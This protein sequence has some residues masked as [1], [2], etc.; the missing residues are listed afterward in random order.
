MF[1]T[2]C[3]QKIGED[4]IF[5]SICGKKIDFK[6][7]LKN[8]INIENKKNINKDIGS[9]K[10]NSKFIAIS[11]E[12]SEIGDIE[13]LKFLGNANKYISSVL[14]EKSQRRL[15]AGY[16]IFLTGL[17]VFVFWSNI[18][19]FIFIC[20]GGLVIWRRRDD[21]EDKKHFVYKFVEENYSSINEFSQDLIKS[22]ED[23]V[24]K[25][26]SYHLTNKFLFRNN[27]FSIEIYPLSQ[28]NWIY[29]KVTR[30]SINF[31]PTG[32]TY[33]IVL[34]FSSRVIEVSGSEEWIDSLLL[35]FFS[36]CP[37]AK[38]GYTK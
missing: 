5:C 11:T 19:G 25:L 9:K 36:L 34:H 4:D 6:F 10:N 20:L 14:I 12:K 32:K 23:G 16:V 30:H 7:S 27:F 15:Y 26:G 38:F 18:I 35:L 29:K 13:H 28:L 31:I 8:G 2:N 33:N 22:Y 21:L 37:T 24:I 1:C 17:L 3:G